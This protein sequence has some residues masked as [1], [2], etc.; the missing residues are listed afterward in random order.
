MRHLSTNT[1]WFSDQFLF[2]QKTDKSSN[3]PKI[4]PQIY[5]DLKKLTPH[6]C[7][8]YVQPWSRTKLIFESFFGSVPRT[9]PGQFY[10]MKL[11]FFGPKSVLLCLRIW[12]E[13]ERK[14]ECRFGVYSWSTHLLFCPKFTGTNTYTLWV[15]GT[16]FLWGFST[17]LLFLCTSES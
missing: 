17:L 12:S 7:R 16:L 14:L 5:P 2:P 8:N 13:I 10:F 3:P 6:P 4:S 15:S 9:L 11:A 1:P